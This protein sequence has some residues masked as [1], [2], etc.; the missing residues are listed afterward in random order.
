MILRKIK[1]KNIRSYYGEHSLEFPRPNYGR[2][3]HLL[4][5]RNGSGKTTLFEA[6]NAC[7]FASESNPILRANYLSR[8]SEG[9]ET[10]MAV[11]LE[12]EHEHEQYRLRRSWA[13]NPG[14]PENSANSVTLHS[15]L[16]NLNARTTENNSDSISGFIDSLMP[17]SISSFFLFD[18]EQIQEYTDAAADSV[19]DALERLLGLSIYLQLQKDLSGRV[20]SDFRKDREDYDVQGDLSEK[21]QVRDSA[22]VQLDANKRNQTQAKKSAAEVKRE[23][24]RLGRQD[25]Q[26]GLMF[27]EDLQAKRRELTGRRDFLLKDVEDKENQLK[28]MISKELILAMFH[29]QLQQAAE[30][31]SESAGPFELEEL[32]GFLWEHRE[33]IAPALGEETPENL[34]NTLMEAVGANPQ[35]AFYSSMSDGIRTLDNLIENSNN[36]LWEVP[37]QL[38]DLKADLAVVSH[39]LDTLPSPESID[40]DVAALHQDMEEARRAQARHESSLS[41]LANEERNL[42][43]ELRRLDTELS[44][45]SSQDRQFRRLDAQL[46][47]CRKIQDVLERFITDY[48]RTRIRELKDVFNR[49]FR[50]LTNSPETLG[51]VEIDEDTFD[52]NIITRTET[53]LMASEQSAGQKEV[54]AFALIASI[55]ELSNKQL[56]III[57]TPLARLDAVH[58]DNI[59][60]KFFPYV[61][62][63]VFV[64]STDTEIGFT[65]YGQISPYIASAHH[66]VRDAET[67]QTSIKEGYLVQ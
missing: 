23:L 7:L 4:G 36:R 50:E 16:Q 11:E 56:P 59:L 31:L 14:R 47:L 62:Q 38:D 45:L 51:V 41:N 20:E 55:V 58:K 29:P 35:S 65:Q 54:M 8:G 37:R 52:I 15:L 44:N 6:I 19:R 57:D 9:Y 63:Q 17:E 39:E 46:N 21:I 61:G 12:F 43:E 64:L 34:Q 2:S 3:I 24:A 40:T 66:L 49:K 27:D 53:G 60:T 5:A 22:Q 32:I 67:G 18:G 28:G 1:V 10:E 48:R 33:D 30:V 25:S 26:I 42:T 13:I